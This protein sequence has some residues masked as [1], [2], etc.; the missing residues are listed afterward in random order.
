MESRDQQSK[1]RFR[2]RAWLLG[3]GLVAAVPLLYISTVG[4]RTCAPLRSASRTR[5]HLLEKYGPP[6]AFTPLA[7]GL[8]PGERLA[9]FIQIRSALQETCRRFQPLQHAMNQVDEV[10]KNDDATGM[11]IAGTAGGLMKVTDN[12]T[13][14][15]GEFFETRNIDIPLERLRFVGSRIG[16]RHIYRNTTF[17]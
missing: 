16:T 11:E 17:M 6:E 14:L 8:I 9:A 1:P 15:I 7:D 13:P 4:A 5:A 2:L 12:I 10:G 3:L